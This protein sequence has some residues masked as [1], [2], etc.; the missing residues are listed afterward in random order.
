MAARLRTGRAFHIGSSYWYLAP[1]GPSRAVLQVRHGIVEEIGIADNQL[2]R[3]R[4][5]AL[6]LLT[7][8]S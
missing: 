4:R 2:T 7:S 1:A 8:F 3:N 6:R 5:A